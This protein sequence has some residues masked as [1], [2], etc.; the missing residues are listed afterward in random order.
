LVNEDE[1]TIV[2]RP[3]EEGREVRVSSRKKKRWNIRKKR[4][5][6]WNKS[7]GRKGLGP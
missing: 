7:G 1:G 4:K 2:K 6:F 5:P 3:G